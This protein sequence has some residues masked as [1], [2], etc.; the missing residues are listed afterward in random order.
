[1]G[2]IIIKYLRKREDR[3]EDCLQCGAFQHSGIIIAF[4]MSAYCLLNKTHI[5]NL[6]LVQAKTLHQ[7]YK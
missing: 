6:N 1:M 2:K 3:N 7:H 4:A 5:F